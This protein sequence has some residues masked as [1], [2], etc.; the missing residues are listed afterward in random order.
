M[1]KRALE[2]SEM[3]ADVPDKQLIR[4]QMEEDRQMN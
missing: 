2:M 3:V 1:E 4:N